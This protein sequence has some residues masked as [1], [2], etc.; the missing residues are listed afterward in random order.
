MQHAIKHGYKEGFNAMSNVTIELTLHECQVMLFAIQAHQA[1]YRKM[2]AN[3]QS[4]GTPEFY[5]DKLKT[6]NRIE[7]AIIEAS[8]NA[9]EG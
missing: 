2:Q 6:A 8:A 9:V 3:P 4:H 5:A 1:T 7:D